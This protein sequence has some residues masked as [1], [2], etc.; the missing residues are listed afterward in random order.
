MS[1][2]SDRK[3]L[4]GI[5][6]WLVLCGVTYLSVMVTVLAATFD[7]FSASSILFYLLAPLAALPVVLGAAFV[8]KWWDDRHA[9]RYLGG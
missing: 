5:R 6:F 9:N 2:A 7:G 8:T 3:G 4:K 1:K